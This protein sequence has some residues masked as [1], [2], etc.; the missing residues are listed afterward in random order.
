MD[1]AEV[2]SV[3]L[4]LAV[5]ERVEGALPLSST[6][7]G[8]RTV[9]L[10]PRLA[11]LTILAPAQLSLARISVTPHTPRTDE[12]IQLLVYVEN[13]GESPGLAHVEVREGATLLQRTTE[14]SVEG[15]STR[16]LTLALQFEVPGVHVLDV[17][18]V[19]PDGEDAIAHE[20]VVQ[21]A[22]PPRE[23][24][25]GGSTAGVAFLLA[26]LGRS[27]VFLRAATGGAP[28]RRRR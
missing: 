19:G 22:Q 5:G 1:G 26:A 6:M 9:A 15:E 14:T 8:A 21:Y 16:A 25:G 18:L 23:V 2:A 28:G 17:R 7:Y 4:Q 12:A 20:L 3:P 11:T 24:A 10:G 13:A 27:A